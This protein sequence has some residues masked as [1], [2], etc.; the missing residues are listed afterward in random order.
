MMR[1]RIGGGLA[2]GF[3]FPFSLPLFE[4]KVGL[5]GGGSNLSGHIL[6]W[7]KK[8]FHR[9]WDALRGLQGPIKASSFPAELQLSTDRSALQWLQQA[10][11]LNHPP[12]S[13][14]VQKFSHSLHI[15]C[16]AQTNLY[17][18]D[19]IAGEKIGMSA[20]KCSLTAVTGASTA[21][22]MAWQTGK[23]LHS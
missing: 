5:V 21:E 20:M 9:C 4:T 11:Y 14:P 6:F 12:N 10:V 23:Q 3:F 7:Q 1:V 17:M 13:R 15:L 2:V 19:G 18:S 8:F 22:V 16:W